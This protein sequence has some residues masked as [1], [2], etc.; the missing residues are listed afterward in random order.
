MAKASGG[1]LTL[2]NVTGYGLLL[3]DGSLRIYP[4]FQDM[5]TSLAICT[6]GMIIVSGQTTI[7]SGL[8]P[9]LIR[10]AVLGNVLSVLNKDVTISLDACPISRTLPLFPIKVLNW[11]QLL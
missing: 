5:V 10:G 4:P 3:V 1:L 2:T 8:S 9:V 6:S 7:E 11:R